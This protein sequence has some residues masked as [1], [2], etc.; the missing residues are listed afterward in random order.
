MLLSEELWSN[1]LVRIEQEI[2]K[3]SFETWFTNTKANSAE[4]GV[5]TVK[6]D[7]A[8]QRDWLQERYAQQIERILWEL[9]VEEWTVEFIEGEK[10]LFHED[11]DTM[12]RPR[13]T[14]NVSDLLSRI[15]NLE[16]RVKEL[17]TK[18]SE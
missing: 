3:K 1:M 15:E 14:A 2:E 13:H 8:F 18:I 9:S 5:L 12:T 7:N 16:A 4:N 11:R 10:A 17:E 6:V